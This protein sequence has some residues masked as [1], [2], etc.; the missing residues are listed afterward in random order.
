[1]TKKKVKNA[2]RIVLFLLVVLAVIVIAINY[3]NT[4]FFA[5]SVEN[6]PNDLYSSETQE[7][8][9]IS[10]QK[11]SNT[12][13]ETYIYTAAELAAFK[14][15]V[16]A[17]NNYEGKTVYLMADIDLSKVCSSTLGSWG[18]IG[19]NSV[20]FA[21]T[22]NGNYHKIKNLYIREN[23]TAVA[24]FKSTTKS[25]TI[26]NLILENVYIYNAYNSGSS[27]T[28]GIAGTNSGTIQNCA[29]MSGSV[30]GYQTAGA[31]GFKG[32]YVGGVIGTNTG[33]VD[34][35]YNKATVFSNA[36]TGINGSEARVGGVIGQHNLN[37]V[38]NCYNGGKVTGT[39]YTSY[40]GGVVGLIHMT[41]GN[42]NKPI[43][44]NGY[45]YG[46]I[47]ANGGT[48]YGAG[49]V[50]LNGHSANFPAGTIQNC[51]CTTVTTYTFNYYSGGYRTSQEGRV[52]SDTMKVYEIKLGSSFAYDIYNKNSRYP[53]LQWENKTPEMKL[54][55]NQAYIKTG[56]TIS[57]NV[58]KTEEI[59]QIIGEN[60]KSSD[61]M[62]KSTNEDIAKVDENGVVTGLTDR[63]YDCI[64]TS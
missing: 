22:F 24:L 7:K 49:V 14:N 59:T 36:N 4:T 27:N 61:F 3:A 23:A 55:K 41:T 32:T 44:K 17:G 50:G 15:N 43:V 13:T 9:Q 12:A 53:V 6:A 26:K 11:L 58:V 1:M 5:M 57:L 46:T 64:C 19:T 2:K 47:T 52:S 37:T 45:N 60:Y 34:G 28:A 16:N 35:C 51:Y 20:V 29:V 56:E 62:W 21:G 30:T 54:N 18:Q 25:T 63:I 8:S 39:G 40:V 38:S 48:K 31:S 10:A 42:P 33:N